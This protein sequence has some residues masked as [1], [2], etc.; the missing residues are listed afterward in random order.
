MKV[1]WMFGSFTKRHKHTWGKDQILPLDPLISKEGCSSGGNDH[2]W[3]Q[4]EL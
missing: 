3:T 2:I 4:G 1:D